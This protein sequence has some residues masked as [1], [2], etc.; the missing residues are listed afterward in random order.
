PENEG[1]VK[2]ANYFVGQVV[3]SM[4][5]SKSATRVVLEMIDEFIDAIQR[6]EAMME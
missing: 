5:E 3:G 6:V 1:A 2:L 4:N